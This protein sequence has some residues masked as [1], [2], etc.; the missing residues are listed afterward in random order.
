MYEE[1]WTKFVKPLRIENKPEWATAKPKL[2]SARTLRGIYIIDPDDREYSD[3][4]KDA[5]RKLER[6]SPP[7]TP[8]YRHPSIVKTSTK[9]KIG[10]EEI[11]NNV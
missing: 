5:R 9:P 11:K 6:F 1:V 2:D 8:C 10:P 4:L 7:A 3:I